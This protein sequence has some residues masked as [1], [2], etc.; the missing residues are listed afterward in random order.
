M[1]TANKIFMD[2][3]RLVFNGVKIKCTGKGV[4]HSLSLKKG[5]IF[6]LRNHRRPP[7]RDAYGFNS[8][9]GYHGL[10]VLTIVQ[11]SHC[12]YSMVQCGFELF[13]S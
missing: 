5:V 9:S 7:T 3:L 10:E 12:I 4:F 8:L 13:L 1:G 2:G 6:Q 11:L